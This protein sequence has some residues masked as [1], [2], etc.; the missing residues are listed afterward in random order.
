MQILG[1]GH[2]R[3]SEDFSALKAGKVLP[4]PLERHD[5]FVFQHGESLSLMSEPEHFYIIG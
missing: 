1:G 4:S 2:S 3:L 5:K